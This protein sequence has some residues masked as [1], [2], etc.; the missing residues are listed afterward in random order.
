VRNLMAAYGLEKQAGEAKSGNGGKAGQAGRG[1]GNGPRG[2][3]M[4]NKGPQK[5]ARAA[6]ARVVTVVATTAT[7][8]TTVAATRAVS[9]RAASPIRC[10]PHWASLT[11]ATSAAAIVRSAVAIRSELHAGRPAG[12]ESPSRRSLMFF[13]ARRQCC[14]GQGLPQVSGA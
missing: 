13:L 4:Q 8:A 10:R 5:G 1:Q 11:P 6:T 14:G 3:G 9:P 7:V 12:H 2:N